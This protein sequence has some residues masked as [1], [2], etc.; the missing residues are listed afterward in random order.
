LELRLVIAHEKFPRFCGKQ[1]HA[2][3]CCVKR[4][5]VA[6]AGNDWVSPMAA[7]FFHANG[8]IFVSNSEI[9]GVVNDPVQVLHRGDRRNR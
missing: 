5:A 8:V 4:A 9:H 1:N 2:E 3:A 7:N 6:D